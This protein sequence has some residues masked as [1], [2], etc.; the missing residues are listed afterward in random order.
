V[1]FNSA[2]VQF[3][4]LI[5]SNGTIRRS[6]HCKVMRTIYKKLEIKNNNSLKKLE[7]NLEMARLIF[8]LRQKRWTRRVDLSVFP[9][10]YHACNAS[11]HHRIHTKVT[12]MYPIQNPSTTKKK[13]KSTLS[14]RDKLE[15]GVTTQTCGIQFF[16][17]Y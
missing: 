7:R 4:K 11:Y 17:L 9:F 10:L 14:K 16:M 12:F 8:L 13:K 6:L 1:E 5:G 15:V 2:D 3:A